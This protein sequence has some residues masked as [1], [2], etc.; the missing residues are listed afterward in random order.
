MR[1]LTQSVTTAILG[2]AIV[3][4]AAQMPSPQASSE[5]AVFK[6]PD[7]GKWMALPDIF[8]KGAEMQV[9]NGDPAKGA[10]E[11]YFRVPSD[12]TFPWH[13]HTPIEK[14]FIDEGSLVFETRN[15]GKDTLDSGDYVYVPARS[16]H[17]VTCSSTTPCL[18]FLASS[19][20]FDI[21][22]VDENWK[23]TKSWR[24]SDA[25]GTTGRR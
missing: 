22:L 5:Q 1:A 19:G 16:P 12:Y 2:V 24:A 6:T 14:L 4:A 9:L 23:T 7:A 3:A 13:F 18:F 17:R 21:H 8:P 11:L 25:V 20:P 15:G 10:A